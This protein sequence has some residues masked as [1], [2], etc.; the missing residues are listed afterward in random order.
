MQPSFKRLIFR[1]L[2]LAGVLTMTACSAHGDLGTSTKAP[3][4]AKPEANVPAEG[5]NDQGTDAGTE[6]ID[7]H[8]TETDPH[9]VGQEI[10]ET[11]D[12]TYE[13]VMTWF[14][15]GYTFDDI[16]IALETSEATNVKA[17]DLLAM[18]KE[19]SWEE[20]WVEVG[21]TQQ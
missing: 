21:F 19:M 4:G 20:V 6:T 17:G 18:S 12:V 8:C 10:A 16:L 7:I 14:C 2:A 9:P 15:S 1:L 3:T 5:D 13:E 11:Y